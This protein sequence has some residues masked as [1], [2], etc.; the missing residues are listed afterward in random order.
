MDIDLQQMKNL[1]KIR[2]RTNTLTTLRNMV[3]Q[4]A[5]KTIDT[6]N[7]CI[8]K[9]LETKG[10]TDETSI[11]QFLDAMPVFIADAYVTQHRK[12]LM[13][14]IPDIIVSEATKIGSEMAQLV[15][16][17]A[18]DAIREAMEDMADKRS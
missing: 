12:E 10:I 14:R 11:K 3:Y 15:S 5:V 1:L 7:H 17:A 13:S 8:L 16:D 4:E 2:I 9:A 18:R 6:S